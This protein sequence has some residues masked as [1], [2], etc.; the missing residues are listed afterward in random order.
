MSNSSIE[1]CINFF[2]KKNV[3]S[4]ELG[5]QHLVPALINSRFSNFHLFFFCKDENKS[6]KNPLLCKVNSIKDEEN[7]HRF[8]NHACC[9]TRHVIV[10]FQPMRSI[11]RNQQVSNRNTLLRLH[12]LFIAITF[13]LTPAILDGQEVGI[14]SD[15]NKPIEERIIYN[16]ENTMH[17]T[18]HTQGL[19]AGFST[20]RSGASTTPPIGTSTYRTY[21]P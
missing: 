2:L 4:L 21:A 3:R 1:I 9:G 20:A 16:R 13:A 14:G 18:L 7:R 11:R 8:V 12:R 15:T 10:P 6:D 5:P 19:G 17:V